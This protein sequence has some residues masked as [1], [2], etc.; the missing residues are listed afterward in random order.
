MAP[1][2]I[3]EVRDR[4][5]YKTIKVDPIVP[6]IGAEIT[7]VDVSAALNASQFQEIHDALMTHQVIFFRDQ[8]LT[9]DALVA[10]AR[11]FGEPHVN[12]DTSFGKLD[13]HP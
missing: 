8:D 9:Q 4:T 5:T 7:G 13:A 1:D 11:C 6:A 2:A 3:G 12:P 10:F